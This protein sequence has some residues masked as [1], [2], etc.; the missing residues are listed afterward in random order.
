MKSA[1]GLLWACVLVGSASAQASVSVPSGYD[2]EIR[3]DESLNPF[4]LGSF[5]VAA[6]GNAYVA[7]DR[8]IFEQPPGGPRRSIHQLVGYFAGALGVVNGLDLYVTDELYGEAWHVDLRTGAVTFGSAPAFTF[9]FAEGPGGE[10]LAS[11]AAGGFG[12]NNGIWVVDFAGGMHREVVR[13]LGPSGSIA[14]DS[15]GNL[16]YATQPATFCP[17]G[18]FAVLRF[19]RARLEAAIAGGPPLDASD[20]TVVLSGLDSAFDLAFDDRDRLY[21]SNSCGGGL[22]RTLPG[23]ATLDPTPF[24]AVPPGNELTL[25]LQFVDGGAETF[26]AYQPT[27]GALWVG[28]NDFSI[29]AE[30][31]TVQTERPQVTSTPAGTVPPGP[32]TIQL[33]DLPPSGNTALCFGLAAPSEVIAFRRGG[34]PVWFGLDPTVLPICI[35]LV[36]SPSGDAQ[37]ALTWAGGGSAPVSCMALGIDASPATGFGTTAVHTVNLTP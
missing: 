10:L 37:L 19:D 18:G 23:A 20:G 16:Y 15:A 9:D 14:F 11:A 35:P 24:I 26:D 13:L 30:I 34:T 5:G 7:V 12:S 27:G 28:I 17:A 4:G 33:S 32:L 29:V 2:S 1:Q 31:R 22:V 25:G 36:A 6:N 8:D 21:I 3:F